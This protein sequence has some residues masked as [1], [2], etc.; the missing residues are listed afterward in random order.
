MFQFT[1]RSNE[2]IIRMTEELN[3]GVVRGLNAFSRLSGRFIAAAGA[4]VLFGWL[5]DIQGLMR[6]FPGFV[7]MNPLTAAC[8]SAAGISLECFWAT[9]AN[10]QPIKSQFGR[11][12]A[13]ALVI[14]GL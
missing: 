8:F 14:I 3:T 7:A 4:V 11:I 9:R 10:A 5:T 1:L 2:P 13:R 12:L 6:V